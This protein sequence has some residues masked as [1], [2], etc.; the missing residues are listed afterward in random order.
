M[1]T[2]ITGAPQLQ[3]RRPTIRHAVPSAMASARAISP[4]A[5]LA[6][7]SVERPAE[8]VYRLDFNPLHARVSR[9]R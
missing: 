7:W 2:W 9:G 5:D 1:R 3:V 4:R 6:V 8:L